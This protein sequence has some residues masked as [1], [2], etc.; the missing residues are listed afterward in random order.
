MDQLIWI[1]AAYAM[2]SVITYFIARR[3]ILELA[4]EA[5]ISSLVQEGFIRHRRDKDGQ[6]ELL[7]WNEDSENE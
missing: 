6:I 5:T 4:I 2:G 7:K 3:G 1:F